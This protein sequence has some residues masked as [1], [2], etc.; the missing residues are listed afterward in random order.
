MKR[1]CQTLKLY[2]NK[3]LIEQYVNE[4]AHVWPEI[5]AGIREVGILDMQ[6]YIKDNLLFMITD[7]AD[8]FDW[9]KDNARLAKLPRQA[10]WE[11]YMA[12]FQQ[13]DPT[14]A[15]SEKWQLMT[16]IFSL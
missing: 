3:D 13:A 11:K 9:E 1:F 12:K 7:T 2:D 16:K 8:D 15:S 4:H 14:A 5:K 10:E 6:I